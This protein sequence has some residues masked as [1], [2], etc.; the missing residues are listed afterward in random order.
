MKSKMNI[1]KLR[2]SV[3]FLFVSLFVYANDNELFWGQTG[4]RVVGEIA[5]QNLTNK[6]KRS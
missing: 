4:H 5:Y 6:A 3:L 1:M 2:I